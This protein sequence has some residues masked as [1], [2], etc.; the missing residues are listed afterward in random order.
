[1]T[2]EY[3][4]SPAIL[5]NSA[6]Y[7]PPLLHWSRSAP[8]T[9]NFKI[10][11]TGSERFRLRVQPSNV[12]TNDFSW[13]DPDIPLDPGST[14]VMNIKAPQFG[15]GL[16]TT[17]IHF[18]ILDGGN[19]IVP[20]GPK[21]PGFVRCTIE[22][23]SVGYG[24]LIIT[25][26]VYDPPGRDVDD[27]S[28][29]AAGDG[30]YVDIKNWTTRNLDLTGC[31]ITQF[32]FNVRTGEASEHELVSFAPDPARFDFGITCLLPVGETLRLLTRE[33]RNGEGP[34]AAGT[35]NTALKF[36]LERK[37]A[38]WNNAGDRATI[39]NSLDHRV[40]SVG[41]G[42]QAAGPNDPT[43]P[44]P[45][46][47]VT[48]GGPKSVVLDHFPVIVPA[49]AADGVEVPFG[50][51][52]GDTVTLD[53]NDAALVD[54]WVANG[55]DGPGTVVLV[56]LFGIV[57]FP[58]GRGEGILPRRALP[59]T[60]APGDAWVPGANLGALAFRIDDGGMAGN[61]AINAGSIVPFTVTLNGAGRLKLVVND[62]KF[63][64][65]SGS[66]IVKVTVER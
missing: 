56:R 29:P 25:D 46:P 2:I 48:G 64:D 5:P 61:W 6:P 18:D 26:F 1:M 8:D 40:A 59:P 58:S 22:D 45:L 41:Y 15:T 57:L 30:E 16:L 31:K 38:A 63:D 50:L 10:T 12:A 44:W 32:T 27:A 62:N 66:F 65:N 20:P 52:D 35:N 42:N 49:N 51:Q 4:T 36:F 7:T 55:I 54:N 53:A 23:V 9:K 60:I 24:D 47:N 33:R 11:N 21:T 34:G 43:P 13:D 3:T 14:R 37:L 39:N 28:G 19:Q 17:D